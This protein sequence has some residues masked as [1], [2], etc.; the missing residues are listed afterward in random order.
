MNE[1]RGDNTR[2]F[3]MLCHLI[4]VIHCPH[5][6]DYQHRQRESEVL[7]RKPLHRNSLTGKFALMVFPQ[8]NR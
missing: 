4:E 6:S 7:R 3:E 1:E 2:G 8:S 5:C